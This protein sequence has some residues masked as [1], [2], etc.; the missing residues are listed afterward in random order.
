MEVR[1][2]SDARAMRVWIRL[3]DVRGPRLGSN[4]S[5]EGLGTSDESIVRCN[6]AEWGMRDGSRF[7]VLQS[8]RVQY[9]KRGVDVCMD[10]LEYYGNLP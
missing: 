7:V 2:D 6:E 3:G 4:D 9:V 8:Y 1:V 10:G 5:L